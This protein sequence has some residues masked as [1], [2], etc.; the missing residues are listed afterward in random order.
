[1]FNIGFQ[2][3]QG[4]SGKKIKTELISTV[5]ALA[6]MV[7]SSQLQLFLV[8]LIFSSEWADDNIIGRQFMPRESGGGFCRVMMIFVL[9]DIIPS[10]SSPFCI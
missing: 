8:C 7:F 5:V 3:V 4:L 2:Q 6:W 1:M 10:P 9:S